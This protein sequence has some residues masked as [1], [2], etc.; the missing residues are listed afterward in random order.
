MIKINCNFLH[1]GLYD[2]CDLHIQKY[3]LERTYEIDLD[4]T[5]PVEPD[6]YNSALG[7]QET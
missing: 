3:E 1:D 6:F 2:I 7:P 4:T 5:E